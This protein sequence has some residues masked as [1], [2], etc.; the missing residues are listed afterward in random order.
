MNLDLIIGHCQFA[1]GAMRPIYDDGQRQYVNDDDGYP[2]YGVWIIPE[3]E[4][5]PPLIVP[6]DENRS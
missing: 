5:T 1:D 4:P 2:V 3:E 6:A